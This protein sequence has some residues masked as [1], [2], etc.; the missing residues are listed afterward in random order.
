MYA[1]RAGVQD[2]CKKLNMVTYHL[3]QLLLRQDGRWR[4]ES[5]EA[6]KPASWI[7]TVESKQGEKTDL[8]SSDLHMCTPQHAHMYKHFFKKIHQDITM[9]Y[10][11]NYKKNGWIV[12]ELNVVL[13]K[14]L[15]GGN[16]VV[17]RT[18]IF[19]RAEGKYS[20]ATQD[21]LHRSSIK[22]ASLKA[23]LSMRVV[24]KE[25]VSKSALS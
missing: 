12:N 8:H 19:P 23:I 5:V 25:I 4:Q 17:Y 18:Y 22:A 10:S 21:L 9:P 6:H 16:Q 13:C 1:M 7:Y 24:Q 20:A 2:L 11:G 3:A 14:K 15:S